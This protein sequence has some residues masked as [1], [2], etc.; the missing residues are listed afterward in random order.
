VT[1]ANTTDEY[2]AFLKYMNRFFR[3]GL[4]DPDA[5]IQASEELRAKAREDRIGAWSD[6]APYVSASRD[7]IYDKNFD[8]L[9]GLT[10][11]YNSTSAVV[12]DSPFSTSVLV[13]I[14]KDTKYP[15][16]ICRL[17]DY[18]YEEQEGHMVGSR[19]FKGISWDYKTFDYAP[20]YPILTMRQPE[21]YASGE[22][23]R[24]KKAV[25]NN[26]TQLVS[27]VAGTQ[28]GMLINAD[29]KILNDERVLNDYGW[30]VPLEIRR[31]E[32]ESLDVF[33]L[34]VFTAEEST[35]RSTLTTDVN[36]FLS[37]SL[38]QFISGEIDIDSG[39]DNYLRTLDQMKASRLIA[40]DQTAYDRM[41]K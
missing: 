7:I 3:E 18:L 31:R 38:T 12:Y 16:V 30:A 40:I 29:E 39:W 23:Y 37:Q 6:A 35:E 27:V 22:E 28:Y 36:L 21:G 41:Y 9:A 4:F 1:L 15:E 25:I 32:C 17:L 34:L 2:K 26:G 20:D 5:L 13:A 14:N 10:S 11:Q 33:P 19:G 8:Y 24:Y